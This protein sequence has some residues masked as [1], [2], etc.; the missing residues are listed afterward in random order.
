[1]GK[2]LPVEL[3]KGGTVSTLASQMKGSI[4]NILSAQMEVGLDGGGL[5]T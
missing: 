3:Q 1:V 2:L 4:E 5:P